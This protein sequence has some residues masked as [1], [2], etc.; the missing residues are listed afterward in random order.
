MSVA[1]LVPLPSLSLPPGQH[2]L[3][4]LAQ[5][6]ISCSGAPPP[7]P[8]LLLCHHSLSCDTLLSALL[9]LEELGVRVFLTF[10][11]Q[12]KHQAWRVAGAACTCEGTLTNACSQDSLPP[13]PPTL[14]LCSSAHGSHPRGKVTHSHGLT[15]VK[16]GP[17]TPL[18]ALFPS[19]CFSPS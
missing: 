5:L 10:E 17:Q 14:L 15:I 4:F 3:S 9:D 18:M 12:R 13:P 6:S 8:A 19:P 1:P 7:G 2:T 16:R 11:F